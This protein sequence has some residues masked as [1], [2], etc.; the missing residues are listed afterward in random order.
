MLG[1]THYLFLAVFRACNEVHS[2]H[3]SNVDLVAQNIG[4]NDFGDISDPG[5][6]SIR[7]LKK[8]ELAF[9]SDSHLNYRL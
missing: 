3:M 6:N 4:E 7:K 5:F 1:Y 2:L 9:S 8:E